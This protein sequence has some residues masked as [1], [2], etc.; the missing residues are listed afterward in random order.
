M[1]PNSAMK[2]MNITQLLCFVHLLSLFDVL[3]VV[4]FAV[5]TELLFALMAEVKRWSKEE[6]L[7]INE[8][9]FSRLFTAF[10]VMKRTRRPTA[11]AQVVLSVSFWLV[12][13]NVF[14][15]WIAF[16]IV[17]KGDSTSKGVRCQRR[18]S[19]LKY[20]CWCCKISG[21]SFMVGDDCIEIWML[22]S[23]SCVTVDG[24]NKYGNVDDMLSEYPCYCIIIVQLIKRTT[25]ILYELLPDW[26][27]IGI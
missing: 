13:R 14:S 20:D 27:V 16:L 11:I 15:I 5:L 10:F 8:Q 4:R 24:I 1:V 12:S 6:F 23:I 3:T 2:M 26:R 18:D 25:I 19:K 9:K 7:C 21:F 22:R 17:T